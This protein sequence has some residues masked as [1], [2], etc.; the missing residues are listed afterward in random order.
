MISAQGTSS[1]VQ[2]AGGYAD[3]SLWTPRIGHRVVMVDKDT[4]IGKESIGD[5]TI[6]ENPQQ[7]NWLHS[8]A[9]APNGDLYAAEVNFT[10]VGIHLS[11]NREMASI[12]KWRKV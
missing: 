12:R 7:F 1:G 4:G 2:K 10:E 11:P 8:V 5:G 6:G 9:I 3:L